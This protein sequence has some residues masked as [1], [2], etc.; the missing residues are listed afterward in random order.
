MN[1]RSLASAALAV[2]SLLNDRSHSAGMRGFIASICPT[3]CCGR[4]LPRLEAAES[5]A[6]LLCRGQDRFNQSP[7]GTGDLLAGSDTATDPPT[8]PSAPKKGAATQH[9]PSW[10]SPFC[11]NAQ[12]LLADAPKLRVQG[13]DS[14]GAATRGQLSPQ[15]SPGCGR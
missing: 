11:S 9:M 15:T 5:R 2:S 7:L 6:H 10:K 12:A 3:R 8:W 4:L 13:A 14:P 1:G